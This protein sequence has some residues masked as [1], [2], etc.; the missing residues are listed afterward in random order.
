V[1]DESEKSA[2][3]VILEDCLQRINVDLK[4]QRIRN[5][6]EMVEMGYVKMDADYLS[7]L[8]ERAVMYPQGQFLKPT[9]RIEKAIQTAE[10]YHA[11]QMRKSSGKKYRTFL[12]F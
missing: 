2:E 10:K 5:R 9:L 11:G 1:T 8:K 4:D 12:I 6:I 7:A 3:E